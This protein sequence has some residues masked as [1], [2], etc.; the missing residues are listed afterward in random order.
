[1]GCGV[2]E[3]LVESPSL[4]NMAT[5]NS[6][7]METAEILTHPWMMGIP[8]TYQWE[9]S[10]EPGFLPHYSGQVSS[11]P[12]LAGVGYKTFSQTR[13]LQVGSRVS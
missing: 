3:G 8:L 9:L 12:A 13:G 4:G 5:H 1:M 2:R 10:A 11:H 6:G 7:A